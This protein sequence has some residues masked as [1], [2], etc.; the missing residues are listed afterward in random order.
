MAGLNVGSLGRRRR[1]PGRDLDRVQAGGAW[2]GG[3]VGSRR[4]EDVVESLRGE[5]G[6]ARA[7]FGLFLL[8]RK[9]REPGVMQENIDFLHG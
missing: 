9:R 1:R 7:F 5:S 6:E 2:R 8:Q 3:E 4:R